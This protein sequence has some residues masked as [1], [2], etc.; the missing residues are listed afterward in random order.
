MVVV[1]ASRMYGVPGVEVVGL[2]PD[3]L[4]TWIGFAT[5]VATRSAH[6][7][8]ARDLVRFMTSPPADLTLRPIGIEPFVDAP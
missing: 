3:A 5:A 6:P 1:V 7:Q 8:E 2:I 4:Q